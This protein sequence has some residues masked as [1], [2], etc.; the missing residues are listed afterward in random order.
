M[1]TKVAELIESCSTRQEK[2]EAIFKFVSQEIRYLGIIP[3]GEDEAP[4]Y[5]PHHVYQ[6]FDNRHGVCRD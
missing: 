3:E 6:T 2:V 4:G 5:Q 1:K